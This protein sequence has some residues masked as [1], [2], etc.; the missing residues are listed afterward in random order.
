MADAI[1]NGMLE[2]RSLT[3]HAIKA[4]VKQLRKHPL[5]TKMISPV[6]TTE[7]SISCFG[8][9]AEKTSSSPSGEHVG[10]YLAC[11]DLKDELS[12]LLVVVHAAM[13]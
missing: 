9:V 3:D 13:M 12:G 8:C 5:L 7:D 2:H 10:H 1:Y 11:T 4:I 6:V